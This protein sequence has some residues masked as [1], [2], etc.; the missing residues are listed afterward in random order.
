MPS[1]CTARLMR[2]YTS[3][4]YTSRVSHKHNCPAMFWNRSVVVYFS[5]ATN[6]RSHGASWS[7]IAPPFIVIRLLED[8]TL[9]QQELD[10]R[11]LAARASDPTRKRE[12]SLQGELTH[13]GKRARKAM[14][15]S[16]KRRNAARSLV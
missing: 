4:L 12:Q 2:A 1:T 11:L 5:T 13:I 9:I 14:R 16:A 3:T 10:R 15:V 6:R 8:P 7:I